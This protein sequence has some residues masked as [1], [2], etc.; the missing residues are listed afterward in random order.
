MEE[1]EY[2]RSAK[3]IHFKNIAEHERVRK[4]LENGGTL[5]FRSLVTL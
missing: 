3:Q 5:T 4:H 2:D 1:S